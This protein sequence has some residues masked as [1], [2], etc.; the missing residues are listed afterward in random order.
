MKRFVTLFAVMATIISGSFTAAGQTVKKDFNL[1][2]FTGIEIGND[3]KVTVQKAP[4][5]IALNVK[6]GRLGVGDT[7]TLKYTLTKKTLA[8][9]KFLLG[10]LRLAPACH[11][12][13]I[14]KKENPHGTSS[15]SAASANSRVDASSP[16]P[17][18]RLEYQ[19]Q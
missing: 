2:G 18:W 9:V 16:A 4:S 13:S 17:L 12:S 14:W 6:T 5:A 11:L 8:S 15:R 10:P 3:F 19:V 1:Q 7:Y